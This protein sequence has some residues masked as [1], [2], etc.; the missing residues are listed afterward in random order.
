MEHQITFFGS[1]TIGD[2]GQIVIPVEARQTFGLKAGDKL[3]FMG[4]SAKGALIVTKPE[5][6]EKHMAD[7]QGHFDTMR[8]KLD[9][10]K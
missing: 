3:I 2:K 7:L 4:H 1:N 10:E 5:I 6:F 9:K 8:K